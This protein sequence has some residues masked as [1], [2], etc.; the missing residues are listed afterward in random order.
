VKKVV[1]KIPEYLGADVV[2]QFDMPDA[3]EV[4][5]VCGVTYHK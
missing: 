4:A 3:T 1:V 2:I 5:K